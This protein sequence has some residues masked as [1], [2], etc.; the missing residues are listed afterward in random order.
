MLSV[1]IALMFS[2]KAKVKIIMIILLIILAKYFLLLSL[3]NFLYNTNGSNQ[4]EV[5]KR[6]IDVA[7][8]MPVSPN[9]FPKINESIKFIKAA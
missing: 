5:I 4:K 6:E 7:I 3:N 8:N 2:I 1:A 9:R